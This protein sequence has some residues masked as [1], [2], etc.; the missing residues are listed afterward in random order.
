MLGKCLC[1]L[2]FTLL[3]LGAQALTPLELITNLESRLIPLPQ[4]GTLIKSYPEKNQSYIY[5]QALAIIAF[6]KE[7]K[8]FEARSL[9]LGLKQLQ[10]SDGSLYFSYYLDGTSPYPQDGDKRFAGAIA[11]V[12][13]AAVTYQQSFHSKEFLDFNQKLLSYLSS[14]IDPKTNALV[15]NPSDLKSTAWEENATAALEHNLD[16]Y[17]AFLQYSELNQHKGFKQNA[18]NLKSYILSLWDQ[19]RSHFWSGSDVKTGAINKQELYLDN[20]TW[21]LLALD[22]R[23]LNELNMRQALQLNCESF[24][25]EHE[26]IVGLMDSKPVRR[27]ASSQFVWSEG[28]AGQILAMSRFNQLNQKNFTCGN[29][30]ETFL[31]ENIKKMRHPHGGIAYSTKTTNPDFTT[32]SSVAGT[33]WL[34]FASKNIN[35]FGSH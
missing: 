9:M 23:T 24:L 27:P 8:L 10:L 20:Q 5:D 26:G 15:F 33:A 16:A 29:H 21:S 4:S 12:A 32:A 7:K 13:M 17:S 35:P 3:S 31:L 18:S 2:G 11:W 19:S 25:V 34:Y 22:K 6:C 28:T 14:Q 30:H 1:L